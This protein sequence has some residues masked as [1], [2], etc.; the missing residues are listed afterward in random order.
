MSLFASNSHK[1][2]GVVYSGYCLINN[3]SIPLKKENSVI[4]PRLQGNVYLQLLTGNFISVSGSSVMIKKDVFEAVGY[5]DESLKASEDWD[6]WIRISKF[7]QFDYVNEELVKIRVHGQNMQKDFPRMLSSELAMLNK[8]SRE[9]IR[10]YFLLWKIQTI[11]FKRAM[12]A[13]TITGFESSEPWVK[14]HFR[15]YRLWLWKAT[16][17]MLNPIWISL[18]KL[19][20]SLNSQK[21]KVNVLD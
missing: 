15:G 8:F 12:Y 2:L 21:K 13:K 4:A 7:F 10:N 18:K 16:L 6:M 17:T 9:G 5:F 3:D 14:S 19:K 11:L 20:S 1:S